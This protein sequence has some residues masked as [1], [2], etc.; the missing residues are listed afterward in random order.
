[1]GE[2]QGEKERQKETGRG[3]WERN[4][5]EKVWEEREKSEKTE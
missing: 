5:G 3:Q 1:M 2:R 4:R